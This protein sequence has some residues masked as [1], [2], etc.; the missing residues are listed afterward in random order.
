MLEIIRQ[1]G[2]WLVV[3][4]LLFPIVLFVGMTLLFTMME[5]L[6]REN[7]KHERDDNFDIF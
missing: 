6:A 4:V 2:F 1:A 5:L 7:K 3:F